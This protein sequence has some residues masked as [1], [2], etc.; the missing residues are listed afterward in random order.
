MN[1]SRSNFGVIIFVLSSTAM[2]QSHL[3]DGEDLLD[4]NQNYYFQE[5]TYYPA[6]SR[7]SFIGPE[8]GSVATL[9][10]SVSKE[11]YEDTVLNFASNL[12]ANSQDIPSDIAEIVEEEFWNMI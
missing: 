9:N 5:D 10:P 6:D 2:S 1:T 12:V 11:S 3:T 8:T 7:G 4:L